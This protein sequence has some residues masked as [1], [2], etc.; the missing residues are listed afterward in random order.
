MRGIHHKARPVRRLL[1]LPPRQDPAQQA[2]PRLVRELTHGRGAVLSLA[3]VLA[4]LSTIASLAVPW[5]VKDLITK[6]GRHE[7]LVAVALLMAGCALGG[8]AAST[9]SS[10]LLQ[11]AGEA[12]ILNLRS[13]A[14]THGLRLPLRTVREQGTGTLVARVTSDAVLLRSLVDTGV[15]QL[16]VAGTTVVLT[17]GVMGYLDWVLAALTIGVF[18][19]VGI[20]VGWVVVR[21]RRNI[22]AQQTSLGALSQRF[23]AVLTSLAT[24]KAYRAEDRTARALRDDAA[25]L[26]QR[27]LAGARLQSLL[28]PV[29]GLGQQIA[30]VG[31]IVIGGARM[32]SGDLSIPDFAAFLLYLMQLAGPVMLLVT[33]V[34][35]IQSGFAARERFTTLLALE[36]EPDQAREAGPEMLPLPTVTAGPALALRDV[37]AGYDG[38][39]ALRGVTFAVP[40]VGLTALVGHSGAGKSTV[41]GLVER[42]LD[43]DSG[44]VE[45]F[46]RDVQKWP[47]SALREQLAYVDQY[48][49]LLEGRVRDNLL[50][51]QQ[52]PD[53]VPQ[54]HIMAVLDAVGLRADI[55]AL[56]QG[57]DT[58]IGRA[59]DLSGGQRQR[60]ALA[61]GLLAPAPL[62]LLDEPTSQLDGINEQRLRTAMTTES[63][64]RA[65]LVVAHRLSTVRHADHVVL[66]DRGQVVDAGGH[67]A[68][69]ER[70][71][72]YRELVHS[73][74]WAA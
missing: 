74:S 28:S 11:R 44:Q 5:F 7:S 41:L 61:R 73:Q 35:R 14:M 12:M 52:D 50:L 58:V 18:T 13:K 63:R 59:T 3:L 65:V 34:N 43:A 27:A 64:R 19:A 68:L 42:F 62:L 71:G 56:P 70:C 46:G 20:T 47:L 39:P 32:A 1:R 48:F 55:E 54:K 67:D 2:P 6:L 4:L 60:L 23:T 8:A 37:H 49:T 53:A 57:L 16:P 45:I 36:Q 15:V 10:Y 40:E 29:M 17:L 51:G 33:G 38:S 9:A 24:I 69:M 25:E 72:A 22:V 30:L 26:G 31:V 66:L 21:V